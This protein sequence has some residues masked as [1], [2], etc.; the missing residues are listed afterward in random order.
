MKIK[1]LQSTVITIPIKTMAEE[2]RQFLNGGFQ[3]FYLKVGLEQIQDIEVVAAALAEAAGLPVCTHAG[4]TFGIGVAAVLHLSASTPNL[5]RRKR[6]HPDHPGQPSPEQY[7]CGESPAAGR[8]QGPPA[9]WHSGRINGRGRGRL[10]QHH[11][12]LGQQLQR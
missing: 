7:R 6:R 11:T 1:D 3:S 4:N 8:S 5:Y 9:R 10:Y 2:A 12:A